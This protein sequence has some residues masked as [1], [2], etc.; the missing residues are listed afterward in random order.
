MLPERY[1][2]VLVSS[3][4]VSPRWLTTRDHVWVDALADI[5]VAR[6]GRS[7]EEVEAALS[8]RP[9]AGESR[10]AWR[11]MC[12]LAMRLHGFE[13]CA[14]AEPRIIRETLF[15][16][17]ADRPGEER[18]TVVADAARALGITPAE[19]DEGLYADLPAA[20]RLVAMNPRL[21][22][23]GLIERYNL[24]LAQGL[25]MRAEGLALRVRQNVK[26]LLRFARLQGL[27][28]VA[29][30]PD[31][32]G[33]EVRL[34]LSGPLSLFRHTLKYGR[35]MAAWLPAIVRTPGWSLRARCVLGGERALWTASCRDPIGTTHAPLKRFDSMIE[36]RLYRDLTRLGTAW[37]VLRETDP[38]QI[39]RRIICPDFTLV[40]PDRG[41]RAQVEIV[42]F[43]TPSYL[44]DKL[45]TLRELPPETSWVLCVDE[46]HAKSFVALPRHRVLPYRRRVDAAALLEVVEA[47][48][49]ADSAMPGR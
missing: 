18:V 28:C 36:E 22:A 12:Y 41:L 6:E 43:W 32:G 15:D 39:G 37:K 33:I 19:V 42:G 29:D 27:L 7:R 13:V 20:R 35:A 45:K 4:R 26:A 49:G 10:R 11:A 3:G 48:V 25:L 31:P 1:C 30:R 46:Q 44:D 16:T 34:R 47:A 2:D 9:F 17:A 5:L 21:C 23:T 8:E 40:D 38:V 24:A 14:A